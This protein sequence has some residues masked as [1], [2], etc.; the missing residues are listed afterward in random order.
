MC[1]FGRVGLAASPGGG[2]RQAPASARR[3]PREARAWSARCAA[4]AAAPASSSEEAAS[5]AARE[6]ARELA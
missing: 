2:E 4:R 5:E 3:R 6:D 1:L